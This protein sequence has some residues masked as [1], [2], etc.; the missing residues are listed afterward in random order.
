MSL[1]EG[2]KRLQFDFSP[3]AE[4][5][6]ETMRENLGFDNKGSVVRSALKNLEWFIRVDNYKKGCKVVI[7]DD[8]DKEL[9]RTDLETLLNDVKK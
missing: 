3:E 9:Y 4:E 5:R 6:V 1:E 2:K 7:L 8:E